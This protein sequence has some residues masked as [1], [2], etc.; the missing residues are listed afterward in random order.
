[1]LNRS[2]RETIKSISSIYDVIS[3]PKSTSPKSGLNFEALNLMI[4]SS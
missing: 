2:N 4:K 3:S 1:M